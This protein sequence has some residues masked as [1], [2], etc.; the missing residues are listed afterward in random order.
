M[1]TEITGKT[2]TKVEVELDVYR[3]TQFESVRDG[4][5]VP[6]W[7]PGGT[8]F[9]TVTGT[10]DPL[11]PSGRGLRTV[12][13]PGGSSSYVRWTVPP[14]IRDVSATALFRTVANN[15]GG[16]ILR[17]SNQEAGLQ[18]GYLMQMLSGATQIVIQRRN[19]GVA[20]ALFTLNFTFTPPELIWMRLDTVN[21]S[22][23]G[24]TVRGKV[25]RGTQADEPDLFMLFADDLSA[26]ITTAGDVGVFVPTPG[27]AYIS[28]VGFFR[29]R[30]ILSN[31]LE[32]ITHITPT[33]IMPPSGAIPDLITV[34]A[35]PLEISLGENLGKRA[36]VTAQFRDHRSADLG[37]FFDRG[38]HWGKFRARQ[39]F[40]RGNKFRT[41]RSLLQ[42]NNPLL[43]LQSETRHY[44]LE[45]FD[46][47]SVA[48]AFS[49]IAQDPIQ[50]ADNERSQCPV[51]NNGFLIADIT[52][53]STSFTASPAG[54]GDLEYPASGH[55]AIG[56]EEIIQFTRVNDVFTVVGGVAGRGQF[57]TI[58]VAHENED[59]IQTCKIF[60]ARTPSEIISDLFINFA[61]ID[62]TLIPLF[63][64]E[65]EEDTYLQ[66][67]Y[68]RVIAE[69][70]GV[71]E[72]VSELIEQ[73]GLAI[74]HDDVDNQIFMQVLRGIPTSAFLYNQT[75]V[76][77]LSVAEQ[78]GKRVTQVWTYFGV[79]NPLESLEEANNYRSILV[80]IDTEGQTE[81]GEA[82]IKKIFGTWIP[83]FGRDA[84]KRVNDLNIGRFKTPP[85][86]FSFE[87]MRYSGVVDPELAGGYQIS[88]WGNQDELGFETLAPF[89]VT[90]VNPLED[91]FQ[92]EGEE[93]LFVAS[94]P[95]DL[96]DR[97]ILIDSNIQN[98]NL[99]T[100]HDSIY[101]ALTPDDLIYPGVT[102]TFIISEGVSVGSNSTSLPACD[103]GTWIANFAPKLVVIGRI[104]GAGGRGANGDGSPASTVGGVALFTRHQ[105]DLDVDQGEIFGG[106]GGGGRGLVFQGESIF[107][108]GGGGGSGNI[109]GI[110]G[111]ANFDSGEPGTTELG[112]NGSSPAGNGGNPGLKG[113]DGNASNGKDPGAAIDGI[114]FVMVIQG[115]GDIRGPQIN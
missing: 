55:V 80:T 103:V 106:G 41:I 109:P 17:A 110:G 108:F 105:L 4:F 112:G 79:R 85:R 96:D 92:V 99:R 57:G 61:H 76:M 20:T 5:P 32:T 69:P 42:P 73:A 58:A 28:H 115:P 93:M 39:L 100:I 86:K 6:E 77:N 56:G 43:T 104:Q 18:N 91:K 81:H 113:G 47:P 46:G 72:L 107:E 37:E 26:P 95:Q 97:V 62:S 21:I 3:A 35:Q 38:S 101:P 31:V 15:N 51:A 98:I 88:W 22:G 7:I 8:P 75:N 45:S 33:A 89:Q 2:S 59:R 60:T 111:S 12:H 102:V 94:T 68:T 114:S 1:S 23:G 52:A 90:K 50:L 63:Q 13:S 44:V 78:P 16:I 74:W 64:W 65:L 34:S 30:S 70:T 25:W 29:V 11:L 48:G 82:V 83:A 84:A 36:K 53:T 10:V 54:I 40:R 66:R 14:P 27:T 9:T 24:V 49:L 67:L 71:N 19:A 87:V